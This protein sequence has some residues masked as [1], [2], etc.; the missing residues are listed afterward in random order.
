MREIIR[1]HRAEIAPGWM[2]VTIAR[3]RAP[4]ADYADLEEDWVRLAK[5]QGL[6]LKPVVSAP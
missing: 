2:F 6:F 3:W 4:E 1:E 5:R